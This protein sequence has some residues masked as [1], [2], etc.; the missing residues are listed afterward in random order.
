MITLQRI[1]CSTLSLLLVSSCTLTAPE[2]PQRVVRVKIL[3][4]PKLRENPRWVEGVKELVGA[5]SDYFK[6]EFG[7][8]FVAQRIGPWPLKERISSTAS[9]LVRLKKQVPLKEGDESNDLVIAFTGEPV[10]IYRD[11]RGRVD[12]VGNCRMGLGNYVV[13]SVFNPFVT[14]GA[15][16]EPE[17]D[18]QA[19]I[20]ELGHIFG[21][22]HTYDT[23]SIM[24]KNF[25]YRTEFDKK[26]RE[27][28][29]K[30]KFCPF[31]KG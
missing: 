21:A 15:D 29:L 30:N 23:D 26:S 13:S 11:A 31:G 24:H 1:V 2:I 25:D 5:A 16:S 20:H 18:L 14:Y 10:D 3:V 6:R 9:L 17:L 12:R 22:G 7:I 19:L 28:I 4:D 27:V 8:R